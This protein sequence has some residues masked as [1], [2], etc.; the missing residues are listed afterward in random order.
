MNNQILAI[1]GG[2]KTIE[3]SFKRYKTIGEEEILAVNEVMKSGVLSKFIGCWEP[4]FLE[5][6]KL[7]N[8][9]KIGRIFW[10]KACYHG[11]FMDFGFN[12]CT[13]CYWFRTRR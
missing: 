1:N 5:G 11:K 7:K 9:K 8:L 13:W 2:P 4:D 10:S 12:L 6:K 3:K